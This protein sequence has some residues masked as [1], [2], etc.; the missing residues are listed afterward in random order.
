MNNETNKKK[1]TAKK[2]TTKKNNNTKKVES[3][4]TSNKKNVKKNEPK[5]N[6]TSKQKTTSKNENKKIKSPAVK[7]IKKKEIIPVKETKKYSEEETRTYKILSYIGILWVVGLLV[8]CK[9]DKSLRFHVGQGMILSI[10]EFI[11]SI[12][13]SLINNLIINNI[14]KTQVSFYGIETGVYKTSALG[15][16]ISGLLNL[17][18]AGFTIGYVLIGIMN[19]TNDKEKKLPI[20]GSLSFFK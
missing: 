19:V 20:I 6:T 7:K 17:L 16:T 9:D 14:F 4:T 8:P 5:K 12:S 2:N 15:L 3:K 18:V 1:S 13:V 10:F 11:F